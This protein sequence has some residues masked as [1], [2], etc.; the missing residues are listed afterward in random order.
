L[1]IFNAATT[2]NHVRNCSF[3]GIP[4]MVKLQ[5]LYIAFAAIDAWMCFEIR[6]DIT[7]IAFS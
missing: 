6:F 2:R 1:D 5:D 3:F 7:P 4:N